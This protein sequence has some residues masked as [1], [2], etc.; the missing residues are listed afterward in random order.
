MNPVDV[1]QNLKK[2]GS[3]IPGV[4]PGRATTEYI[5]RILNRLT[6]LGAI[7]LGLIATVPTAVESATRVTTFKGLGATSLLI[8]VGVAIDTAKQIQTYVISQ[9][10]EGMVKE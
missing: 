8:L 4:R 6:F 10:Y 3:S 1:S 5:E 2:M 9:R 7:F